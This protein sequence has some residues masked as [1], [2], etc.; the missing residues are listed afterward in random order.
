MSI[1]TLVLGASGTGKSTSLRNLDPS[2]TLLI[3]CI[4]KPLPFRASDWKPCTKENPD[5]NVVRTSNPAAI[6]RAMKNSKQEVV[7]ID[8][9]FGV[10]VTEIL[11]PVERVTEM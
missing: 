11:S 4:N 9:N 7:V 5:G 3:Q 2:N 1:A 6:L 10:R 8:E